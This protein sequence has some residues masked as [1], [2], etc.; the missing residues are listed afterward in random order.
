MSRPH[1]T[2]SK[3]LPVPEERARIPYRVLPASMHG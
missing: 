1:I 2:D 3:P